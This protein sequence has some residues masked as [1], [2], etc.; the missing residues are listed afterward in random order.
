[1]ILALDT[2]SPTTKLAL[3]NLSGQTLELQEVETGNKLTEV[4]TNLIEKLLDPKKLKLSDLTGLILVDGPGSFTGLR[5]GAS[6]FNALAYALDIPIVG[7][8]EG[9]TWLEGG[10]S[11]LSLG[12]NDKIVKLNYGADPH[13]T[14]QK[15]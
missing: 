15:K 10:F 4:L 2:S 13:I 9:E 12:D 6:T 3:L 11:R 14:Q 1:M 8:P 5:I 7:I